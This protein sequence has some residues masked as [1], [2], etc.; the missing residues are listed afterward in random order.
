MGKNEKELKHKKRSPEEGKAHEQGQSDVGTETL[1]EENRRKEE[2]G[3]DEES[4]REEA[5]EEETKVA[6]DLE[7]ARPKDSTGG[8]KPTGFISHTLHHLFSGKSSRLLFE[9]PK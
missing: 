2:Q 8:G 1:A 7:H 3:V 6:T 4:K 5:G 9:H